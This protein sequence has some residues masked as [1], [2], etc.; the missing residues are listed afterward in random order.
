MRYNQIIQAQMDALARQYG[1]RQLPSMDRSN[2]P[3]DLGWGVAYFSINGPSERI[4]DI[5][6]N[7]GMENP[8]NLPEKA[9]EEPVKPVAPYVRMIIIPS[10]SPK[11]ILRDRRTFLQYS[12]LSRVQKAKANFIPEEERTLFDFSK[13]DRITAKTRRTEYFMLARLTDDGV[14]PTTWLC[15][16]R[17]YDGMRAYL[18]PITLLQPGMDVAHADLEAVVSTAQLEPITTWTE[19]VPSGLPLGTMLISKDNVT[20]FVRSVADD[21]LHWPLKEV[22]MRESAASTVLGRVGVVDRR[23]GRKKGV[24][25]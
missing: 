18:R 21:P 16:Q 23:Y 13:K 11:H 3:D 20:A 19:H 7:V 14:D 5:I 24:S 2:F 12:Q 1:A 10:V 4:L 15:Q 17:N 25:E 9:K 6:R 8:A 22:C